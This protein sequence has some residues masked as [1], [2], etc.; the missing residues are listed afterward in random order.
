MNRPKNKSVQQSPS[1]SQ[2]RGFAKTQ[3]SG[4]GGEIIGFKTEL[5]TTKKKK[6]KEEEQH[7][8]RI[9]EKEL[10]SVLSKEIGAGTVRG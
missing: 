6:R 2:R 9:S 4:I 1:L 8:Q 3:Y 10:I 5:S 7:L